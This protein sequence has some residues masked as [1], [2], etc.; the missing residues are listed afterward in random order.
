MTSRD[1][2]DFRSICSAEFELEGSSS[3]GQL[4]HHIVVVALIHRQLEAWEITNE[5][6]TRGGQHVELSEPHRLTF[7][8]D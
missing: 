2:C 4:E 8:R 3:R 5:H 6:V 7:M 1:P